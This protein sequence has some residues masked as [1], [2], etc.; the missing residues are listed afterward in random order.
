MQE[1]V[2]GRT[3]HL[4]MVLITVV[5]AVAVLVETKWVPVILVETEQTD[6]AVAAAEKAAKKARAKA[7]NP[8][9]E[10]QGVTFAQV[11]V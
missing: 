1:A 9:L 6:L 10:V 8:L 2:E 7:A 5:V 3:T 4:L 11:T